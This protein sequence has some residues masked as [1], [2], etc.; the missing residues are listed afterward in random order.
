MFVCM[1]IW[2]TLPLRNWDKYLIT[3]AE[4]TSHCTPFVQYSYILHIRNVIR[5]FCILTMY[6]RMH[7]CMIDCYF[8]GSIFI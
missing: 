6:V 5:W 4:T 7:V 8:I 3:L 2:L 1:Y